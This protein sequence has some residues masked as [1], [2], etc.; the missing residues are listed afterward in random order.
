[1]RIY[2]LLIYLAMAAAAVFTSRAQEEIQFRPGK[3]TQQD[4]PE[5]VANLLESKLS[6][7][8]N[9]CS[10]ATGGDFGVFVV[11]PTLALNSEESTSGLV[12]NV[13]VIAGELTLTAKNDFDNASYY[14]VTV[15]LKVTA[16]SSG[17]DPLLQLAKSIKVT[18][19]VYVRFVRTARAN[20]LKY[21]EQNCGNAITRAQTL[22]LAGK[23]DDALM[24]LMAIPPTASCVQQAKL[25]IAYIKEREASQPQQSAPAQEAAPEPAPA[26]A[27]TAAPEPTPAPTP[28]P[29]P[30]PAPVPQTV[31]AEIFISEPGWEA[32]VVDCRYV[33][34][35][36]RVVITVKVKSLDKTLD[37][38]YT[39]AEQ[40]VDADGKQY[41][42]LG[43]S[44]N[45]NTFPNGVGV[46]ID[47]YIDEVYSNPGNI[48]MYKFEVGNVKF[49]LRNLQ[50]K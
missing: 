26:P 8:L 10:A 33:P 12:Q 4:L 9:R 30:A 35:N 36:R 31:P 39:T 2:R 47:F 29:A 50:V 37:N 16:K 48:A 25:L 19:P 22:I 43:L 5:A 46:K 17:E 49:E 20:I 14:S 24:L 28:A 15:P 21:Y 3:V 40:A 45:F 1:M 6:Q 7:I 42:K 11:E 34:T 13:T 41:R 32:E 27:P 44:S 23:T 38:R 18:E